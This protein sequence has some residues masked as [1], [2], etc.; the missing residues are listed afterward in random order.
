MKK[1]TQRPM[2]QGREKG[3]RGAQDWD[4]RNGW[5]YVSTRCFNGSFAPNVKELVDNG[6][7]L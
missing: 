2:R 5:C 6:V 4:R 3:V 1:S 7:I